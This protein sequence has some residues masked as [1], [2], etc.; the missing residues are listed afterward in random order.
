MKKYAALLLAVILCLSLCACGTVVVTESD[1]PSTPGG[2][3]AA[4]T[5]QQPAGTKKAVTPLQ[6]ETAYEVADYAELTLI[7]ISTTGKVEGSM[8]GGLYYENS[9]TGE[10]YID[11]VFDIVNT[12]TEPIS[13]EDFMTATAMN[14]S[15]AVYK[16]H[17]YC[18]ETHDMTYVQSYEKIA[19]LSAARFHAAISVPTTEKHL[20]LNFTVNGE[21]FSYAY[22]TGMEVK[23]TIDLHVGDVIENADYATMKFLGCE[24]T[25]D[26][27]P[28]NTS[29]YYSHYQVDSADNT[30]LVLKFEVTNYQT[31]DKDVDT[32]VSA[33][34]T[35]MGKYKYTGFIVSEDTDGKGFSNYSSISP[36]STAKVFYLIEIPKTVADKEFTVGIMFDKQEYT[37][38][39]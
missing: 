28:S 32:F 3:S 20:T 31:G 2:N 24:M 14:A 39:G 22:D 25:D 38:A 10:T 33:K 19:P 29:G 37:F 34:A 13:S 36:L 6:L 17:L 30:Y 8:G 16:C 11:A 4:D 23:T 12:G 26:L 27:L 7:R 15:G 35:F 5:T 1:T 18:V 9:T 21:S